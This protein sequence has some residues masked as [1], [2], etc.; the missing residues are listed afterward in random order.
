MAAV[1]APVSVE[2]TELRLVGI[3]ALGGEIFHD[4]HEVISIH[5]QTVGLHPRGSFF[6]SDRAE[7]VEHL[8]LLGHGA[9]GSGE[10]RHVLGSRLDSVDHILLDFLQI[11][12]ADR[13]VEDEE[14]GRADLDV[15]GGVDQ[16]HAILGG[17]GALVELAGETLDGDVG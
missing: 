1:V 9:F 17:G 11:L 16:F 2:N 5:G 4:L 10:D 14:F 13:I 7:T 3:A 8:D 15:G 12:L 6:G